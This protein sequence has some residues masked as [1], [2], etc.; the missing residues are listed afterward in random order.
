[1]SMLLL[2]LFVEWLYPLY[3][4]MDQGQ[5]K[6]IH[7]FMVLTASLLVTG[8]LQLPK[9]MHTALPIFFILGAMYFFYGIGDG[10]SWFVHYVE[11][12]TQDVLELV[13]SGQLGRIST[14]SRAL[15]LLIGWSL[16]VVSVQMLA[17]GKDSVILFFLVTLLYLLVLNIAGDVQIVPSLIRVAFWGLALQMLLF[18]NEMRSMVSYSPLREKTRLLVSVGVLLVCVAGSVLLTSMLPVQPERQIP[19]GKVIEVMDKWNGSDHVPSSL[20]SISGYGRDDTVLGSPL[21]LRYDPYFTAISS[22]KTYW[23]GESKSLY[24]GSGWKQPTSSYSTVRIEVGD[25]SI[26]TNS[27]VQIEE[28]EIR[29]TVIFEQPQSTHKNFPLFA[30]GL[31]IRVDKLYSEGDGD[32]D[33]R[34]DVLSDS[35]PHTGMSSVPSTIKHDS[36]SDA[37]YVEDRLSIWGYELTSKLQTYSVDELRRNT[38]SDPEAIKELY[39]QLP[40]H[41][42][43]RVQQLGRELAQHSENRYEA[44]LKV[45]D[46]LKS[47]YKYSLESRAPARDHDFVDYF[48]FEQ[49]SGYCDHFSTAM[50]ILLRSVDIP[51]RWVKGFAPVA[52]ESEDGKRYVVTYADAHSWVEVYFPESGWIPF[53][54]TPG[55]ESFSGVNDRIIDRDMMTSTSEGSLWTKSVDTFTKSVHLAWSAVSRVGYTWWNQVKSI[56]VNRLI[57]VLSVGFA[58]FVGWAYRRTIVRKQWF[59]LQLLMLKLRRTFPDRNQLLS[60]ADTVWREIYKLHGVKAKNMTAREYVNYLKESKDETED[61]HDL[62]QF[63]EIWE[64]LFYGGIRLNR[65]QSTWFLK[66]CI[67]LAFSTRE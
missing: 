28:T 2:A 49:Q 19:W 13:K 46:Y 58:V 50:A 8:C 24:T 34:S 62:E 20:Y 10:V 32:L 4:L 6:V 57:I 51:T 23:R 44:V 15:F 16:L 64:N 38:D 7:L 37:V 61:F 42:P 59:Q 31:P 25:S 12:L 41:L 33:S 63:V 1:M 67:Q 40:D 53:D 27:R 65:T 35:N 55:Y 47:S 43:D 56:G 30:G 39:L 45:M 48:L 14:E 52:P 54:P 18:S 29:Q 17:I 11:L 60:A 26:L 9:W 5:D 22:Y 36:S 21:K 66:R 3:S